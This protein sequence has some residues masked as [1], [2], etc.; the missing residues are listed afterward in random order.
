[1]AMFPAVLVSNID[2]IKKCLEHIPPDRFI[3]KKEIERRIAKYSSRALS[4]A[5]SIL[6]YLGLVEAKG[7]GRNR[8]YRRKDSEESLISA[9]IRA[10]DVRETLRCVMLGITKRRDIADRVYGKHRGA[11]S[12][13]QM[14]ISAIISLGRG[15][16]IVLK[17]KKYGLT[18]YGKRILLEY[19]LEK[20]YD[21]ERKS[22]G[23]STIPIEKLRKKI[24]TLLGI[25]RKRFDEI[26]L[27]ISQK[28]SDVILSPAPAV[29]EEIRKEGIPTNSGVL[30]HI[31]I[32]S[33][34][35]FTGG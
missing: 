29:N 7:R 4:N 11:I 9:Y 24:T 23:V 20:T 19:Y 34:K 31:R 10:E 1:M 16:G 26:L 25:T 32:L 33:Y 30:Y 6:V 2:I 27:E 5:L 17:A 3:S 22:L 12:T 15:L 21:E 13:K 35:Y 28:R 18:N 14:R 8:K